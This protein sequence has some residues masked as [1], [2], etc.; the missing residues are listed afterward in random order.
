MSLVRYLFIM[1]ALLLSSC[2]INE[3]K[4]IAGLHDVRIEIKDVEIKGGVQKAM[5]SYQQ[6]L[7]NTP[8]SAMTPEALRR[9]ADLNIEQEYGVISEDEQGDSESDCR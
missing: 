4:T 7:E 9:L 3:Q 8:E 6:F 5:Q 2:A 1:C